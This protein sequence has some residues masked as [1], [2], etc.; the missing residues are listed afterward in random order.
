MKSFVSGRPYWWQWFT[1]LSL[2][3]TFA[4]VAWQAV[5][6]RAAN[7]PLRPGHPAILGASVW[8]AY[9]ADRWIEGW[10]LSPD[11]ARTQRHFFAVRWRWPLLVVWVAVCVG[12]VA[13]AITS[14]TLRE[15]VAGTALLAA[16]AA[17][18][19]SHQLLHRHHRWRLPKELCVA[20]LMVGGVSVFPLAQPG[21][22][23]WSLV[24]VEFGFGAL[25]FANVALISLWEREVDIAHGQESIARRL[26][27]AA[28]FGRVLPWLLAGVALGASGLHPRGWNQRA[29]ACVAAS[30]ALLGGVDL[31]ERHTGRQLARVLADVVLLTPF[32]ALLLP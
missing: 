30:S 25:C 20:A 21:V 17:Y 2:D 18:L 10:R 6:F 23:A 15:F 16:V 12:D 13:L 29:L 7:V 11:Q 24:P 26:G 4:A 8:L 9:A 28:P 27:R 22:N 5:T 3:A 19:L 32:I 31:L 14:L 1:I